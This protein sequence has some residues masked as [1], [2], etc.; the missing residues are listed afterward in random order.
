LGTKE[1]LKGEKSGIVAD[2]CAGGSKRNAALKLLYTHEKVNRSIGQF[3]LA[4]GGDEN[5]IRFVL[6]E[7]IIVF[8]R[9]VREDQFRNDSQWDTFLIGIGKNICRNHMRSRKSWTPLEDMDGAE[10]SQH[11]SEAADAHFNRRELGDLLSEVL[12]ELKPP[13]RE[14]LMLWSQNYT[15]ER[16]ARVMDLG[17]PAN[18]RKRKYRCMKELMQFIKTRPQ[19]GH[20]LQEAWKTIK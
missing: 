19:V 13:C 5:D 17:R 6:Q 16:I 10:L 9:L 1:T 2:I 15:M 8:D 20:D 18:A 11:A 7:S 12:D 14:V 3:V 4:Y